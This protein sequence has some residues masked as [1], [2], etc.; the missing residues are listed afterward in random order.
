[1]I[2]HSKLVSIIIPVYNVDQYLSKCLDSVIHQ[3]YHN[4]E[5]ICVNDASSDNSLEILKEYASEDNRIKI[6]NNAH[7]KGLASSRNI[8]L[9]AVRGDFVL[10]V[11]SDDWIDVDTIE[12]CVENINRTRADFIAFGLVQ[13]I[14]D[15]QEHKNPEHVSREQLTIQQPIDAYMFSKVGVTAWTKF[16]NRDFLVKHQIVFPDGR[17][18]EDNPFSWICYVCAEKITLLP[19]C[20]YHY[21]KRTGSIT[22]S[23]KQNNLAKSL[24]L[25]EVLQYFYDYLKKHGYW[26]IQKKNFSIC[27]DS[28][29]STALKNV[30][31]LSQQRDFIKH[32]QVRAK[33]WDWEPL[34]WSL[35]YDLIHKGQIGSWH[36]YRWVKSIRKRIAKFGGG[37]MS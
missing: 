21:R 7:N 16:F 12:H 25:L 22:T 15:T 10:F 14:D 5:I 19:D 28:L 26:E 30:V 34:K 3:T 27:V 20:F 31:P 4:L 35:T 6:L 33:E 8:A 11:D 2:N 36:L 24:D 32:F 1:M 17:L 37:A 9:K 23:S 18:F 29:M 13:Y